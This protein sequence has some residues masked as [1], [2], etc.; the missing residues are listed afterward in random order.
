MIGWLADEITA[1][2]LTPQ[3][4]AAEP[5]YVDTAALP[6]D[7]QIAELNLVRLDTAV[8]AREIGG[9]RQDRHTCAVELSVVDADFPRGMTRRDRIVTNLVGRLEGGALRGLTSPEGFEQ[10]TRWGWSVDFGALEDEALKAF[11]RWTVTVLVDVS[12]AGAPLVPYAYGG[13]Y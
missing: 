2:I 1:R 9:G 5:A 10:V 3:A 8:V 6:L 12:P 11:A 7:V 13:G 4:V